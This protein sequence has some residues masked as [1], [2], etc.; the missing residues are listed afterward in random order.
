MISAASEI[1][2]FAEDGERLDRMVPTYGSVM[3]LPSG[4]VTVPVPVL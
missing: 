1:I 2:A 3:V 4:V